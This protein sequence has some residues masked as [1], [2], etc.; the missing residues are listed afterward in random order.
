MPARGVQPGGRR[1]HPYAYTRATPP[2][3]LYQHA[4]AAQMSRGVLVSRDN[5]YDAPSTSAVFEMKSDR[6][7]AR[8]PLPEQL[9]SARRDLERPHPADRGT[10]RLARLLE[11]VRHELTKWRGGS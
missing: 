11:R 2:I 4:R 1:E 7:D 5:S 3:E 8:D 10:R 6:G 9:K